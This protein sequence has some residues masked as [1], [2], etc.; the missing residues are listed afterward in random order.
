MGRPQSDGARH[1]SAGANGY[2]VWHRSLPWALPVQGKF[3]P[4]LLFLF[5]F[6]LALDT[7]TPREAGAEGLLTVLGWPNGQACCT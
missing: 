5:R 2:A 1:W 7:L 6:K 4:L 3:K